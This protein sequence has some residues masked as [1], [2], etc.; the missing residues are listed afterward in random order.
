MTKP[1]ML[2]DLNLEPLRTLLQGYMD[3]VEKV[4]PYG[5]DH[6]DSGDYHEAEDY[7]HHIFEAAIIAFFG[8]D[9]FAGYIN[10]KLV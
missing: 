9:A 4:V 8:P 2:D 7:E 6:P 3:A 10:K 1:E 5:S